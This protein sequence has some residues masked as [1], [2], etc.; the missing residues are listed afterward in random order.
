VIEEPKVKFL[1]LLHKLATFVI[2]LFRVTLHNP[3]DLFHVLGIA[4]FAVLQIATP[5]LDVRTFT[6][7]DILDLAPGS[8]RWKLQA[9]P[10]IPASISVLECNGLALLAKKTKARKVF[11]FGTYMGVSATHLALNLEPGGLVYSLDL[12]EDNPTALL[13][14][15]D[16]DEKG[17]T[18]EK[19]KGSLVPDDVK[20]QVVFLKSDSAVF[21]ETPYRNS[22]D[23]VFVDGAHSSEYVRSDTE[24]ALR[25]LRQGG[26][27]AWHDCHHKYPDVVRYLKTLSQEVFLVSGT[28]LAFAQKA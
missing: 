5:E 26:I 19:G 9:F 17:L 18:V 13:T 6:S 10:G 22:M 3:A 24:K 28:T 15:H 8:I 7:I 21:D 2:G 23:L 20:N 14:I 1:S 27:V 4:R 11:E 16:L 12:P 25:M